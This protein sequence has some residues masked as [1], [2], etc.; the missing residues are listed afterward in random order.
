MSEPSKRQRVWG[1]MFF[2]WAQQPYATLGLTFIFA[3]YF[4]S[5]AAERFATGPGDMAQAGAQAQSLWSAAQTVAGL[6]IAFSAPFLGAYADASGRKKPWFIV[7]VATAALCAL[8]LWGLTPDG[9]TLYP[10]LAL[11][12]IGFVASESAFNLNNAI[13][14]SLGDRSE[15]GKIS[16]SAAA[17]G[18]WGGVLALFLML[19]FFAE[20]DGG[21][22]LIGLDPAFGLDAEAREGTRFVGPFIA[23]WFVLFS[24]PFFAWTKDPPDT[25]RARPAFPV[26]LATLWA[27]LRD[28]AARPSARAFLLGSMFYRDGLTALYAYGGIYAGRVLGWDI[29]QIGVFGIIAA[30]TAAILSW[31]GGKADARYGPKPVIR[32]CIWVL[33]AVGCVIVGM[34][35]Q[36]L[37][38]VPLPEGS[39]LPDVVFFI[40]GALIGGMG[41][42]LYSA[43]RS[44]MT[45]H[46][47]TGREAEDFGLFA[48]TGRAT[49][50]LAPALITLFTVLTQSIQLGFLPVI[51]LFLIGLFL[52]RWVHPLGDRA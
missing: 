43:S 49:A 16:G 22:T 17:F 35:R 8:S 10:M 46:C 9:A 5:V 14:P 18:Y 2:D 50:F 20:N 7:F 39:A 48:L 29:I 31:L 15:V 4:A 24:I 23:L 52:L 34:S 45:R 21:T 12:W 42:I 13:L 3:P 44:L 41:G 1:W 47:R 40:C 26:V 6:V 38:G 33:V 51:A 11:F 37:F 36:S 27:S 19:L 30:I 25:G 28:V 32:L